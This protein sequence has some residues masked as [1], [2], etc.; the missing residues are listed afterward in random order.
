MHARM[1]LTDSGGLQEEACVLGTPC[2]T[3]RWNTERPITIVENGGTN[4]L[5]GNDPKKIR[6]GFRQMVN[7]PREEHRPD[8][9]DGR[10]AERVVAALVNRT[11]Y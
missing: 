9:W 3:L 4:I 10:T 2:L 1:L 6:N 11:K 5:V 7:F 8:M